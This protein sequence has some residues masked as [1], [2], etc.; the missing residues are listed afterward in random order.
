M[1]LAFFS[2]SEVEFGATVP[3]TSAVCRALRRHVRT[4]LTLSILRWLLGRSTLSV[5]LLLL[6]LQRIAKLNR[7]HLKL[8]SRHLRWLKWHECR[9]LLVLS[10]RRRCSR[11]VRLTRLGQ[12]VQLLLRL[13]LAIWLLTCEPWGCDDPTSALKHVVLLLWWLLLLAVWS[14]ERFALDRRLLLTHNLCSSREWHRLAR[15]LLTSVLLLLLLSCCALL[16]HQKLVHHLA[17]LSCM[18]K[19]WIRGQRS[20]V[21]LL[22]HLLRLLCLLLS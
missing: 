8:I 13:L 5:C 1:L 2:R 14:S 18:D 15:H 7:I 19:P 20:L 22:L 4:G 3:F 12:I 16:L 21:K 10:W 6:L 9:W 17:S 11:L